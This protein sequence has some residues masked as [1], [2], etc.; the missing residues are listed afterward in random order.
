M[1]TCC[2]QQWALNNYQQ[3]I[4][5]LSNSFFDDDDDDDDAFFD[6]IICNRGDEIG[7]DGFADDFPDTF[8]AAA[9]NLFANFCA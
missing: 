3:Q 8:D 1:R 9:T 7:A 4:P 2:G 5:H 6:E